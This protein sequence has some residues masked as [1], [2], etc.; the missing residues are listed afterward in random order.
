[1][2]VSVGACAS[3]HGGGGGTARA[4]PPLRAPPAAMPTFVLWVKAELENVAEIAAPAGHAWCIDVQ[5]AA[6]TEEKKGV[7]V[8]PAEEAELSGSR[9]VAN[10]VI[11]FDNKEA[12]A[13]LVDIK[14]CVRE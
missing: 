8:D 13:S 3:A 4:R 1:M 5:Q 7:W 11:K 10:L 12:S 9:G 6:G 14:V 2:C